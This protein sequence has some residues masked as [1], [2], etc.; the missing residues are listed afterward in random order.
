MKSIKVVLFVLLFFTVAVN[1]QEEVTKHPGYIDF[2]SFDGL[3]D[4]EQYTEINIE[5]PLLKLVSNAT[6]KDAELSSLLNGLKLIKVYNFEVK[7]NKGSDVKE[8]LDRITK[9]LI[10]EKWE[11]IV[12]VKDKGEDVGIY[13]KY[14]DDKIAGLTVLSQEQSGEASFINIVGHIDLEVIS[15][16]SDK[17]DIPEL[18][19]LKKNKKK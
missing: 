8:K 9:K 15:K 2:G 14:S 5:G 10:S 17:F 1:A 4:P 16:L 12:K 3:Y 18:D 11:R 7:N 19:N 6:E 13:I